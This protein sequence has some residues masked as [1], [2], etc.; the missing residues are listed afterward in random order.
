MHVQFQLQNHTVIE[1]TCIVP[2]N[3]TTDLNFEYTILEPELWWPTGYGKPSLYHIELQVVHATISDLVFDTKSLNLG[4]RHIELIQAPVPSFLKTE[5]TGTSFFFRING[6]NIFIKGSNWIPNEHFITSSWVKNMLSPK[7]KFL[8]HSVLAANMNMLRVW[9]GGNY[10][11]Q[12]FYEFCDEH[13]ILVWQ[14]FMFACSMYP[15]DSSFIDEIYAEVSQQLLRLRHHASIV[16]WGGNNENESIMDQFE[17]GTFMPSD[18]TF[19]RQIYV[20]D[21]VRIYL[22]TV[23]TL[24]FELDAHQ[25]PFVDTSPSNGVL[26]LSSTEYIKVWGNTSN[27][28]SGD[29][30]FYN[31][32]ED[33]EQDEIYPDARFVSEFGF[34]SQPSFQSYGRVSEP[35]DWHVHNSSF[36]DFRQRHEHGNKQMLN[37]LQ[38][39]FSI[40]NENHTRQ[41]KRAFEAYL[42]LTQIQQARC[43]ATAIQKW[44]Q[45]LNQSADE[46]CRLLPIGGILYWQLNDIWQG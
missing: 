29:V 30:H 25:R 44:H 27:G 13:G 28:E 4:L 40:P 18:A 24:V 46:D 1:K 45:L 31:Y 39:R 26:P 37:Q 22:D 36:L 8:L 16:I 17:A 23:R 11:S 6:Q 9:G 15:R 35:S 12:A 14:E 34:Q 42:V 41:D 2:L 7:L 19:Q 38:R 33:C 20:V 10:E 21:F 3:S 43:Y 32:H 5:T